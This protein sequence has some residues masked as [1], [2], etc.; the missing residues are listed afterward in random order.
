MQTRK[1]KYVYV[2]KLDMGMFYVGSTY[3]VK[4]RFEQ[5]LCGKGS[6]WTKTYKPISIVKVVECQTLGESLITEDA[7]TLWLMVKYSKGS[8][9]GGRWMKEGHKHIYGFKE[10]QKVIRDKSLTQE[11]VRQAFIDIIKW[12]IPDN[13]WYW[14]DMFKQFPKMKKGYAFKSLG[15]VPAIVKHHWKQQRAI[16]NSQ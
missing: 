3:D 9:R 6:E 15:K 1:I 7:L 14:D 10:A 11:Q 13:S 4:K 12:T 5:H 2:L 16:K 8:V